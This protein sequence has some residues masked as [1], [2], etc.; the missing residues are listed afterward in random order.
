MNFFNVDSLI[1]IVKW[2]SDNAN[3][4]DRLTIH[5]YGEELFT[6]EPIQISDVIIRRIGMRILSSMIFSFFK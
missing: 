3:D 1:K 6:I 5:I 2:H 4:E